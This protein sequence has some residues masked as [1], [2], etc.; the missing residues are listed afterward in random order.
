MPL[1]DFKCTDGHGFERFLPLSEYD[2]PQKCECGADAVKQLSAPMV[3]GD[4]PGYTSP[5][6]GRWVEGRTAR[7]EDLRRTGC[8][9]WEPGMRQDSER[10]SSE[11]DNR[12]EETLESVVS[13]ELAQLP[14]RSRES[15]EKEVQA[16][17]SAE[18]VRGSP[19]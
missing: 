6:D 18:V 11:K 14:A 12:F 7:R 16:G 3:L 4:L 15:L 1:Y 10:K 2:T 8:V 9:P 17:A 13:T 5:V 19:T